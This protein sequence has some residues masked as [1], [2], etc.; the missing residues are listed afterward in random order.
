MFT[1]NRS[2]INPKFEGYKLGL[3]SQETCVAR[4]PLPY[5]ATQST[6]STSSPL[7]FEE[8]QSRVTHNHISV[9]PDALRA[10]YVDTQYRVILVELNTVGYLSLQAVNWLIRRQE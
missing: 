8:V 5:G 6:V 7:S 2:L 10:V 4:H 1:T 9:A 3:V